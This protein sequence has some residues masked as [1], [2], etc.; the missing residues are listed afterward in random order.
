MRAAANVNPVGQATDALRLSLVDSN[1]VRSQFRGVAQTGL[2]VP[3]RLQGEERGA[4]ALQFSSEII[5]EPLP[6]D[7]PT[8]R[9]PDLTLARAVLG[10]ESQVSLREGL[11]R[12]APWFARKLGV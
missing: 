3:R 2:M 12:T 4:R 6:V 10:F 9:R 11:E 1:L 5:F 8:Q 7:D